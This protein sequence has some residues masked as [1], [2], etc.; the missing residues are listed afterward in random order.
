MDAVSGDVSRITARNVSKALL[1]Y[2]VGTLPDNHG[3]TWSV[4][5]AKILAPWNYK[6]KHWTELVIDLVRWNIEVLDS[7]WYQIKDKELQNHL[8]PVAK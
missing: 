8:E 6:A 5:N 7:D 1:N 2:F 3:R 4:V